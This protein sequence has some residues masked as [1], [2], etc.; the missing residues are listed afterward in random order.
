VC[1]TTRNQACATTR[2]QARD[3]RGDAR[4][5]VPRDE[6]ELTVDELATA[7]GIPVRRIRFYA[8]KKLLPPPRLDGRTGLYGPAHLARLQLIAD[9]QDAG[10]TLSAIEDFLAGL[11]DD[12][13]ADAVELV[14][15]LVAPG[16][17]GPAL[18]LRREEL[19]ERLGRSLDEA[20]LQ[21]LERANLLQVG[22]DGLL[23]LTQAQLDFAR[24]M[25]AVDAPLD[26]LVEAGV[27]VR[28]HARSLAED[29][30]GVFERRI[31][32]EYED[33]DPQDRERLRETARA[34]RPLTIQAIVSAYQESLE[35]IIR[36]SRDA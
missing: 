16:S 33:P 24:R 30:Q 1:A 10:Y 12:A 6:D 26:A 22:D 23:H 4:T 18:V 32:A 17:S 14:G 3:G 21:S 20:Q 15:T 28:Q 5:D 13:D 34:L 27:L 9:L 36:E 29:L 11:P 7:A 8:G 35:Q 25:L 2:N 31:L 19:V